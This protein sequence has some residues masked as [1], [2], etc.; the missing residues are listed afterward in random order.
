M[1]KSNFWMQNPK[2]AIKM[3]NQKI[4]TLRW[5]CLPPAPLY[6]V[7]IYTPL[8]FSACNAWYHDTPHDQ[9]NELN[10]NLGPFITFSWPSDVQE[11]T[12][13]LAAS[14]E[15]IGFLWLE[16]NHLYDKFT[17]LATNCKMQLSTC[18]TRRWSQC[19]RYLAYLRRG[20]FQNF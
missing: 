10:A 7:H 18:H 16:M 6:S 4:V 13:P 15:D 3:R 14:F 1:W 9:N 8:I 19:G 12:L 17:N 20:A 5:H 11:C 2:W